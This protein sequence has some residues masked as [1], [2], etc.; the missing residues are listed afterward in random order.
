VE[1]ISLNPRRGGFALAE[2]LVVVSVLGILAAVV[3]LA[4]G[5]VGG[6][7]RANA[8]KADALA[9]RTAIEAYR[10]SEGHAATDDPTVAQLVRAGQLRQAPTRWTIG[11]ANH[12][13]TLTAVANAGC[14]GTA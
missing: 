4:V 5:G 8:C 12:T 13:P 10:A 1:S 9:L 11:Y 7:G 6:K 14:T 2:V 3:V